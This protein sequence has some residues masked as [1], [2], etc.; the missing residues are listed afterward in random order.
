MSATVIRL[1]FYVIWFLGAVSQAYFT[2]IS[3]DEAYYWMYSNNLAWGYF[4]HP[5]VIAGLIKVGYSIFGNELGVRLLPAILS[6]L[7]IFFIE[8][9]VQPKNVKIFFLLIY[10]IGILHFMSFTAIPDSPLLFSLSI[11]LLLYKNF[12]K[13]QTSKVFYL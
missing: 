10:S 4:D 12:L 5:P 13:P 7:T 3:P 11:F 6:T 9:I 8:R 1:I 2:Q